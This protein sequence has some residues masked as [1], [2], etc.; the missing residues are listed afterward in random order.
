MDDSLPT[1]LIRDD[2]L[3]KHK[4]SIN[5]GIKINISE[6]VAPSHFGTNYKY[7][8]HRGVGKH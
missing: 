5:P 4:M 1:L 2:I 8:K 7:F 6:L 3:D